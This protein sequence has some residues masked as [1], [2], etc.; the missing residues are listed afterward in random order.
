MSQFPRWHQQGYLLMTN[1]QP[2]GLWLVVSFADGDRVRVKA[3][4]LLP[5]DT[6]PVDW[7]RLTFNSHEIGVPSAEEI[8]IIPSDRV[9]VLTDKTFAA[10]LARMADEQARHVGRRIRELREARGLAGEELAERAGIDAG[11]LSQIEEGQHEVVLPMLQA[12]LAAMNCTVRDVALLEDDPA[13]MV[14][15]S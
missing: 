2:E 5:P 6:A 13:A 7:D 4:R 11:E 9:R 3:D 1:V 10:H 8:V 14:V 15:P 12:I